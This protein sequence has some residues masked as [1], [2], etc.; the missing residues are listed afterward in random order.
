M[1]SNT[2][3]ARATSVIGGFL[4]ASLV[5]GAA[6]ITDAKAQSAETSDAAKAC[7]AKPYHVWRAPNAAGDLNPK[8]NRPF[9][10]ASKGSCRLDTKAVRAAIEAGK[11]K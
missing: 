3:A 11:V 4:L 6:T 10:R 8:T 5:I 2:I 9:K 7:A 1:I